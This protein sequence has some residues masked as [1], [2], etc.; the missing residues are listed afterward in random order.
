VDFWIDQYMH[1]G[2]LTSS[3]A[4][5]AHSALK[6]HIRASTVDMV[7]AFQ[8]INSFIS[9]QNNELKMRLK[10]ERK[11]IPQRCK[12]SLYELQTKNRWKHFSTHS[13]A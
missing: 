9:L 3:R 12:A 2:C 1:L 8:G 13:K 10:D 6:K 11:K 4:E 5:S 7:E